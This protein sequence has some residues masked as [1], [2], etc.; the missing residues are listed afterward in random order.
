[1]FLDLSLQ[2]A[3]WFMH[4]CPVKAEW[5]RIKKHGMLELVDD[6]EQVRQTAV[7]WQCSINR[8]P[9]SAGFNPLPLG[10]DP[11]RGGTA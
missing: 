2:Y 3:G 11:V 4:S 5:G 8:R 7:Q 6:A 1:M 10:M 9:I